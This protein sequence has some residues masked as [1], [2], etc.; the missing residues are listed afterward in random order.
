MRR[1]GKR[2]FMCNM[3]LIAELTRAQ[4]FEH[5]LR[6]ETVNS[7]KIDISTWSTKKNANNTSKEGY[8]RGEQIKRWHIKETAREK[9]F[10]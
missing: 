1:H 3:A 9:L 4:N 5:F 6:M 7:R 2:L 8:F 10:L